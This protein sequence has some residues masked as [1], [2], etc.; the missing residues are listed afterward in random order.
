MGHTHSHTVSGCQNNTHMG[1][2]KHGPTVDN[3]MHCDYPGGTHLDNHF[4]DNYHVFGKHHGHNVDMHT[5]ISGIEGQNIDIRVNI[6]GGGHS[7]VAAIG[8][9]HF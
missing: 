5:Q 7:S 3:N 6:P 9:W 4:T 2:N 8:T 1:V